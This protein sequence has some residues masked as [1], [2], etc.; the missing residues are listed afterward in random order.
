MQLGICFTH[1][2][3]YTH[4][5]GLSCLLT[6]LVNWNI[7]NKNNLIN[8]SFIL[9]AISGN[10][11]CYLCECN[12]KADFTADKVCDSSVIDLN[13]VM[14]EGHLTKEV[15]VNIVLALS[16]DQVQSASQSYTWKLSLCPSDGLFF[17]P[18][19]HLRPLPSLQL[20]GGLF[21]STSGNI[22][23]WVED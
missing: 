14:E 12:L 13:E 20:A 6:Q 17:L 4:T 8:C 1:N 11:R 21:A 9:K 5:F 18:P 15:I 22:W 3:Y 2:S 19:G 10:I 7:L 23:S 16:F